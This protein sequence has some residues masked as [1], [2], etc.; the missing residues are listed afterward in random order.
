MPRKLV[1]ADYFTRSVRE[2]GKEASVA[3]AL[4]Q[5]LLPIRFVDAARILAGPKGIGDG[6]GARM[7]D[8]IQGVEHRA[9]LVGRETSN[10]AEVYDAILVGHRND[11][12]DDLL[13]RLALQ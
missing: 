5:Q 4:C 12:I 3:T 13:R 9:G 6:S 2:R 11:G 8:C 10:P 1:D 7:V